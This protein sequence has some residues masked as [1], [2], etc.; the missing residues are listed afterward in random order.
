LDRR[1]PRA[2]FDGRTTRRG[3]L[4]GSALGLAGGLLPAW[5]SRAIEAGKPADAGDSSAASARAPNAP[6]EI[7]IQSFTLRRYAFEPMLD[8]LVRLGVRRVELIPYLG[9]FF[10][11][12]G[13]H[14]PVSDDGAA[15]DA[16]LRALATRG[17][18]I[19]ASGVHS[20]PDAAEAKRLFDFAERARIPLLTISP[21]D[22]ALDA[23]DRL[24][25]ERPSI[26]V[27][28]HN[29]GP[30]T[31]YDKL[32][33]LEA[34]LVGRAPNF[35][36]CVDT[37]HLIRSGE[38]PVEALRRLGPRVHGLHLKDHVEAG[39]F[40]SGCLLGEGRLDLDGC[41]RALREIGFRPDG[42]ISLELEWDSD[43]L[44]GDVARCLET[45]RAA[46]ARV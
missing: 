32:A 42:A 8:E 23:I 39:F 41:F 18:S 22:E 14:L 6:F 30:Y 1:D 29:H 38:D 16:A 31:R 19:S 37:G 28:I 44:Q 17:L 10:Y 43:G 11:T 35:G 2:L 13:S 12:F 7:G 40:A 21:D 9:F 34:T 20:I 3:F 25:R 46:A 36:A 26:R 45:A 27:G 4:A 24:C 5:V 33:D 15:I